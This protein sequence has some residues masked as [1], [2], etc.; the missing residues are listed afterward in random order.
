[1]LEAFSCLGDYV[2]SHIIINGSPPSEGFQ[3]PGLPVIEV[4]PYAPE[5]CVEEE[6][7]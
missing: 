2:M 5:C 4:R 1:M 3:G 7:Y 6:F